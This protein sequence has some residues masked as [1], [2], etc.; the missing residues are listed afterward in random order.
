MN[1]RMNVECDSNLV[2]NPKSFKQLSKAFL[3]YKYT[4][5]VCGA[6][7]DRRTHKLITSL[8]HRMRVV[9]SLKTSVLHFKSKVTEM[10]TLWTWMR[11]QTTFKFK[12]HYIY[13]HF[14]KHN[15]IKASRRGM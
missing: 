3:K 6:W 11:P 15:T 4:M 9:A 14:S 7:W 5:E 10:I 8:R 12:E 13:M 1:F 2:D